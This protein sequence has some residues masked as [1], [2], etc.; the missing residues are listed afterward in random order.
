MVQENPKISISGWERER[1]RIR[2]ADFRRYRSTFSEKF[3]FM[4]LEL[5]MPNK[6]ARI[7]S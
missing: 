6:E 1:I 4:L 5:D 3:H 7:F 2:N